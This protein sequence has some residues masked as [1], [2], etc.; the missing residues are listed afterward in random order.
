MKSKIITKLTSGLLLCTMFAYTMP[1]LA[2]TKE[3]KVFTKLDSNGEVY[4]TI[5]STHI[6]NED[7]EKLINDLSETKTLSK[8]AIN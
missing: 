1:V 7:G 8:K 2:Y 5:V 4:N 6:K 3:E